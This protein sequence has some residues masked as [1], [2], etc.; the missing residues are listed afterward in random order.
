[1]NITTQYIKSERTLRMLT[2]NQQLSSHLTMLI[3]VM[4]IDSK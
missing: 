1:M 2:K 3:S 4:N